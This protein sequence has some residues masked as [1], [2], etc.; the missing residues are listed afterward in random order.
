MA[1]ISI[2]Q[3]SDNTQYNIKD[4]KARANLANEFSTSSTYVVGDVVLYQGDLYKC[5][6]AVTTAGAWDSSKWTQTKITNETGGDMSKSVY[7]VNNA[8]IVDR[9]TGDANGNEITTT[10][11]TISNVSAI[12]DRVE[13]L[14][15]AGYITNSVNNLTNY[16]T[17]DQINTKDVNYNKVNNEI[18][19][20]TFSS[21]NFTNLSNMTITEGDNDFTFKVTSRS[22]QASFRLNLSPDDLQHDLHIA[23]N[24]SNLTCIPAVYL[25][26]SA[27][28][29]LNNDC[30]FRNGVSYIHIKKADVKTS[31]ILSFILYA[32]QY[33]GIADGGTFITIGKEYKTSTSNFY[34][35]DNTKNLGDLLNDS[36]QYKGIK[37]RH[38]YKELAIAY[39][40]VN[41]ITSIVRENNDLSITLTVA[42]QGIQSTKFTETSGKLHIK[43]Q[44]PLT[45]NNIGIY[46]YTFESNNTSHANSWA[47]TAGSTIDLTLDLAFYSVY[48]SMATWRIIINSGD[49]GTFTIKDLAI[50]VDEIS[51]ME[52]YADNLQDTL[53]NIQNKF[54]QIDSLLLNGQELISPNG[55]KYRLVVSNEGVLSTALTSSTITKALFIGN[56]LLNGFG[57]HG[58]ASYSNE[59]DYYYYVC[60]YLL[61]ENAD[62]TASK[63]SGGDWE[64]A[65]TEANVNTFITNTLTP[66][67]TNDTD[68]VFIQLGDNCNTDAKINYIS[69]KLPMLVE[70]IRTIN[71]TA[72]IYWIASW[73]NSSAKQTLLVNGCARYGIKYINIAPLNIADNRAYIGYEYLDNNGNTKTISNEG[74]AS[75]PSSTGMQ[76][77]ANLIISNL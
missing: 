55:T 22:S 12:D 19:T 72:Q 52:I 74:V 30:I 76:N 5:T 39:N 27:S 23:I 35:F 28:A 51:D 34:D 8:G 46:F 36:S 7:D 64:S 37:N 10:Y 54:S 38:N 66:A 20:R 47:I 16:Y 31:T 61:S 21:S 17:K 15:N 49:T 9:A 50:Y 56:S 24:V 26:S 58:M 65:T 75:H 4:A 11:E 77:I 67:M 1:D 71:P 32:N 69:T 41:N 45:S 29:G 33:N 57:N 73:Y 44:V 14:E 18:V 6:T 43:G 3:L 62:F 63:I 70:A 13:V 68:T 60:Q 59:D 2:I 42:G 25:Y 40:N 48:Q 53:I